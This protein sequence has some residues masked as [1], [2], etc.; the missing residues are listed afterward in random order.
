M[1]TPTSPF[2]MKPLFLEAGYWALRVYAQLQVRMQELRYI[3][4]K[5]RKPDKTLYFPNNL[6][7]LEL[8]SL[9]YVVSPLINL[10][11]I[12]FQKPGK[13]IQP[14]NISISAYLVKH[15]NGLTWQHSCCELLIRFF[16]DRVHPDLHR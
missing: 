15:I 8:E 1:N 3:I 9:Q 13:Q 14:Q 16:S 6:I 12:V 2:E 10:I 5:L 7:E 4:R 11:S